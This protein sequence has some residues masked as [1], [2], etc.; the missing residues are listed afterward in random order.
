MKK[1]MNW[2]LM[3]AVVLGFSLS[4]TACSDDDD[5]DINGT[6]QSSDASEQA[7]NKK[8]GEGVL[9][10]Y[11]AGS[12]LDKLLNGNNGAEDS[13]YFFLEKA[14]EQ[15]NVLMGKYYSCRYSYL[16]TSADG[17]PIWLTGRMAWPQDGK[18]DYIIG[19]C[20]ITMTDNMSCP[21]LTT[22]MSS[23]C[24]IT[25]MLFASKALVVFPDYE[26]YG[27]TM[28][29][30]HP[31]LYQEVTA[32]QVVDGIV[33][34]RKQFLEQRGGTLKDDYQTILLGYSQGGSV[35]MATH[36]YLERGFG[37]KEPLA[38]DLH[39]A[40][41]ICGDGPYDPVATLKHYVTTN[42]LCMPVVAPL[43]V[44]GMC[45]AN[46]YVA[47]HHKIEDYLCADFLNSGIVDWLSAKSIGT[48]AIQKRLCD[49]S[50]NHSTG[51]G[52]Y[53]VT[54]DDSVFVMY[55]YARE[56]TGW[57]SSED[58]GFMPITVENNSRY[59][60]RDNNGDRYATAGVVLR[61][62]VREYF[63]NGGGVEGGLNAMFNMPPAHVKDMHYALA[64]N[65]VT[66]DWV[67][68]RP[69]IVFHSKY[70]EVVPFVNYEKARTMFSPGNFH[71]VIYD[72]SVQ[73]HISVGKCFFTLYLTSYITDIR[74][75]NA[76]SMPFEKTMT[77][78]W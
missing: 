76:E 18:A 75:G 13:L 40:G 23:D 41:S 25:C 28:D 44:K 53:T 9:E 30:A 52:Q 38:G 47:G 45:D 32:R 59:S 34:A 6:E 33:A 66:T 77:G 19:G 35:A 60:W 10:S 78:A 57:L 63:C 29:R 11:D 61:P 73:T 14:K 22:S 72:T 48:D 5:D 62:E 65:N 24:G 17:K 55:G 42:R 74:N 54:A 51:T 69:M 43:I 15:G 26:G 8:P 2:W 56:S 16:S 49:Y 58:R 39:L 21:S 71:G 20:H 68:K 1:V 50:A 64:M 46:P 27:N 70:D 37:S 36:K 67:P 12:E 31:Y 3:A 4:F 7:V